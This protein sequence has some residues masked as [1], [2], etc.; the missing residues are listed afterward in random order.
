MTT[1]TALRPIV[2]TLPEPLTGDWGALDGVKVDGATLTID[3]ASYF[4]RYENATWLVC[5]W[6]DVQAD[7]LG[8]VETPEVAL[9][10]TVLDYVREH[11]QSTSD[12]AQVLAIAWEVYAYLFRDDQLSDPDLAD[13]A[14]RDLR[15]LREIGTVMALNRVELTGEISNVGPAWFFGDTARVVFGLTEAETLTLDELYH[16]GFFNEARRVAS[17]KA[18]AALGGRLVHGCQSAP[19]QSGGVVAPYGC[20]VARFHAELAAFKAGWRHRI[21]S[22]IKS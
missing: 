14:P 18:H 2:V 6:S 11:G 4:F 22:Q 12:P 8:E 7:L 17:I 9:E 1:A 21:V 3:P 15:I 13:V 19:N 10:Q 16:G 20:D 5:D